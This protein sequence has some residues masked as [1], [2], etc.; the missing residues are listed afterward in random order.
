MYRLATDDPSRARDPGNMP[1][2][3]GPTAAAGRRGPRSR[4]ARRV[5]RGLDLTLATCGLAAAAPVMLIIALLI[6]LR[7]GDPVLYRQVRPG[8]NGDPF[9]L[10]KFRTMRHPDPG[11]SDLEDSRGRVTRLGSA[12]RRTSLDEL[13]ELWNVIRGEMSIVGPRPLLTEF[14]DYYTPEQARRHD[15]L[16]GMTGWAQVHGRRNVPM[17]QRIELDIW[18]VDNWSLRLDAHIMLA[19]LGQIVRG[20]DSEPV[21]AVPIEELGWS[22]TAHS[23]SVEAESEG[24]GG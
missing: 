16:P 12:L 5:K 18:Y 22:T 11:R 21:R 7:M 13:P 3:P 24:S 2:S 8:L 20:S 6:R 17:Q 14:L 23:P 10:L 4:L 15:V 19:T 9:T 1:A